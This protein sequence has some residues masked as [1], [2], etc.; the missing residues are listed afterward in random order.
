MALRRSNIA[1]QFEQA[2]KVAAAQRQ[3]LAAIEGAMPKWTEEM[4]GAAHSLKQSEV[5]RLTQE[6]REVRRQLLAP[7]E[8]DLDEVD[9]AV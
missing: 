9:E 2:S 3:S 7:R 1:E 4:K 5:D 6:E 8:T